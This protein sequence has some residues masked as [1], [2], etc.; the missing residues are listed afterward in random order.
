[1]ENNKELREQK[2]DVLTI[3]EIFEKWSTVPLHIRHWLTLTNQ[4]NQTSQI[5]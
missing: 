5:A 4:P 1:M 3:E 2:E